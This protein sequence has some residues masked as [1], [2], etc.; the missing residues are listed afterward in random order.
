MVISG[1]PK[2]YPFGCPDMSISGH[3]VGLPNG[4][5]LG[6]LGMVISRHPD[7]IPNGSHLRPLWVLKIVPEWVPGNTHQGSVSPTP[8]ATPLFAFPSPQNYTPLRISLS[9]ELYP[10]SHFPLRG[11]IPLFAFPPARNHSFPYSTKHSRSEHL[12]LCGK[13]HCQPVGTMHQGFTSL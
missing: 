5:P 6:W 8:G 7:G 10:S 9:A 1:H 13:E 2:G 12:P 4:D 11:T 3:P